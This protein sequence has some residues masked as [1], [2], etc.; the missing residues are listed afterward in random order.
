MFEN[1][2]KFRLHELSSRLAV[3]S[4]YISTI[5]VTIPSNAYLEQ[6]FTMYTRCLGVLLTL[7]TSEQA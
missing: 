2:E 1:Y 5:M 4:K 3:S 6:D 7:L